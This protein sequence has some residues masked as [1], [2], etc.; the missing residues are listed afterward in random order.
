MCVCVCVCVCVI[1]AGSPGSG[2]HSK[3]HKLKTLSHTHTHTKKHAVSLAFVK[4]STRRR[5][6]L[7]IHNEVTAEVLKWVFSLLLYCVMKHFCA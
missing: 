7:K 4:L 1:S 3:T 2:M 5:T 6:A